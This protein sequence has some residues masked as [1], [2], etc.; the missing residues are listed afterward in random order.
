MKLTRLIRVAGRAI[1]R[2]KMRSSLTMLGIIIGVATVVAMVGI[3]QGASQ[4]VQNQISAMGDN[5]VMIMSGGGPRGGVHRGPGSRMT[6]TEGDAEAISQRA[7]SIALVAPLVHGSAQVIAGNQ[8]WPTS[9]QGSTPDYFAIRE[10]NPSSGRLFLASEAKSGSKVCVLGA[11]VA[12]NLFPDAEAVGAIIR[13]KNLPF[14]VVGVLESK[15]ASGFGSDQD[16]VIIAPLKAVQRRIVGTTFVHMIFCSATSR[17]D[18]PEAREQIA[19]ILRARHRIIAE[20]DDDFHIRAQTDIA[21]T[22]ESVTGVLTTML[23]SIAAV[24]LL[25][26]GIGIMNIMLVSVTER[27]RE[28]GIRMAVGARARDI[29]W[30]FIVEAIVLSMAGGFLGVLTGIGICR[31][32]SRFVGWATTVEP[33]TVAMA[34]VFSSLVGIFFGFYPARKAARLDPIQALHYE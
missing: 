19:T 15:G 8:N 4:S 28:I 26:G 14:L 9:I 12:E 3:G 29:M 2:N 33:E 16:D 17:Q 23:G 13:I 1:R 18:V 10:L 31:A 32:V 25:V 30:Q 6:L 27:T 24:S 22:A 34:L 5:V 20:D 21:E 7:P 11:T